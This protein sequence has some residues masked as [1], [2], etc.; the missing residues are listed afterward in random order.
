M[1]RYGRFERNL[2]EMLQS[3]TDME[4][5][6]R[7]YLATGVEAYLGSYYDAQPKLEKIRDRVVSNLSDWR[8]SPVA[9]DEMVAAIDGRI[10]MLEVML[11]NYSSGQRSEALS[12]SWLEADREAMDRVR[13]LRRKIQEAVGAESTLSIRDIDQDLQ[14]S[15]WMMLAF[16]ASACAL[17]AIGAL[18]LMRSLRRAEALATS[19]A[20]KEAEYRQLAVS[21]QQAMEAERT[22]MAR[23][24]HDEIGQNLTASKIDI[25]LARRAMPLEMK[26]AHTRLE[27]AMGVLDQTIEVARGIS[28]ELR[29]A[30]LDQ[31]GLVAAIAWQLG[32]FSKRTGIR[33]HFAEVPE[34]EIA[35][36]AKVAMFRVLQEA[37]TNVARHANGTDVMVSLLHKEDGALMLIKDNGVGFVPDEQ[38][39]RSLGILGMHERMRAVSGSLE[40]SSQP[41][42]GTVVEVWSPKQ[43]AEG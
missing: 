1:E 10:E 16:G 27:E 41:G 33:S 8:A 3:L 35:A 18:Q 26:E 37:L 42:Q 9:A 20:A 11:D 38:G 22:A 24:V 31:A 23:R 7:Y 40:I 5:S 14:R 29:P 30:V 36:A 6:A 4:T 34:P 43:T 13:R 15:H 39:T 21:L 17:L 32:E 2:R 28:R 19:V 25:S 12:R